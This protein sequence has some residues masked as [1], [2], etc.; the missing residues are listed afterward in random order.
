MAEAEAKK[1]RKEEATSRK[2]K[3]AEKLQVLTRQSGQSTHSLLEA[4]IGALESVSQ[5]EASLLVLVKL[6]RDITAPYENCT[7]SPLTSAA[8]GVSH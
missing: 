3:R 2:E 4:V 1:R 7:V 6:I 5:D 8:T